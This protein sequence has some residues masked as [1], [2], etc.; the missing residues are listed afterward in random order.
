[1]TRNDIIDYMVKE[2]FN[3]PALMKLTNKELFRMFIICLALNS[4]NILH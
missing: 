2:G 4:D 3:K 1:M